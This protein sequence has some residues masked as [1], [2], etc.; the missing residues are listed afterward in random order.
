MTAG[1]KVYAMTVVAG[2]SGYYCVVGYGG[3]GGVPESDAVV[4][5][6]WGIFSI[7]VYGVVDYL[8]VLTVI[9]TDC[10]AAGSGCIGL[11]YYKVFD[12]DLAIPV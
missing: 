8:V 11:G 9:Y 6:V 4:I 5:R 1:S 3:V 12:G 2:G 10:R 7:H